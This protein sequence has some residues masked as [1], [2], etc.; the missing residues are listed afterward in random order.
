MGSIASASAIAS[1]RICGGRQYRT[2]TCIR[3]GFVR[4]SGGGAGL[5]TNLVRSAEKDDETRVENSYSQA[6]YCSSSDSQIGLVMLM[7]DEDTLG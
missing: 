4:I 5:G 7:K 1:K 6:D 3:S 2:L